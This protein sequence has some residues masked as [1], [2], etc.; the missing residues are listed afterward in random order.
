V[1]LDG[2]SR[3][4]LTRIPPAAG[5]TVMGTGIVSIALRRPG[6][7]TVSLILLWVAAALW[8]GLALLVVR[9]LLAAPRAVVDG[10]TDPGSLTAVAATCVLGTRLVE[11]GWPVPAAVLLG[12]G[13][14]GLAPLLVAVLR[15]W[16]RPAPGAGFLTCVAPQGVAVLAAQLA[17]RT[18]TGWLLWPGLAA[19]AAGLALYL[20]TLRS[21]DRAELR[22][23]GGD[24]WVAGGALAIS[25]LAAATLSSTAAGPA[26]AP[27]LAAVL[28]AV[29]EGVWVL[30]IGWLPALLIGEA[31]WPRLGSRVQRWATVF[32]VGMYAAMS[33]AVGRSEHHAWMGQIARTGAWVALGV[34]VVVAVGTLA[35]L[36]GSRSPRGPRLGAITATSGRPRGS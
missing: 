17:S 22:L 4:R 26:A 11:Q 28:R 36:A 18:A 33:G 31:A 27:Q 8:A 23:G 21:F 10:A 25:A 16:R 24:Q 14:L 30:A 15:H 9:R 29:G 5:A 34:W 32:P 1:E 6:G 7:E 20:H 35:A 13:A 3:R 12:L 19:F 2:G